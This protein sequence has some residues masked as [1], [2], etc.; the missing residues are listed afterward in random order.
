MSSQQTPPAET[1]LQELLARLEHLENKHAFQE[2]VVEQLNLVIAEQN[3]A[4]LKMER[5]LR[6]MAERFQA[7]QP[8]MIAAE[9]EETLPP[10]Y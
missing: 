10:H 9:S 5:Q 2:D 8:S 6:L 7:L 3:A 1:S 4:L